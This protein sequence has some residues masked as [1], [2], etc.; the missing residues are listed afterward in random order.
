[1]CLFDSVC[2]LHTLADEEKLTLDF[3]NQH[4]CI[5]EDSCFHS[6]PQPCHHQG[7]VRSVL[8]QQQN[9]RTVTSGSG[10]LFLFR[11]FQS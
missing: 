5:K 9:K 2:I 6:S 3:Q 11:L 10:Q 1:M 7:H 8:E 4:E